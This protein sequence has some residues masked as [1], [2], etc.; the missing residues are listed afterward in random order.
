[1]PAVDITI[2]NRTFQLVCGDGQ[3]THL[4]NLASSV[5]ERVEKLSESMGN[6]NDTLLLVMA[7]LMMQDQINDYASGSTPANS[8]NQDEAINQ[9]VTEAVTAIS[10]YVDS[11]ADRIEAGN[12]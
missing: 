7:S 11:V 5:S 1:M 8:D 3:E 12:A 4:Q 9:A 2:G 6:S 10:E